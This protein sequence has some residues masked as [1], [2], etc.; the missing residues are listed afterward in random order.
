MPLGYWQASVT[1]TPWGSAFSRVKVTATGMFVVRQPS[2]RLLP[3][4]TFSA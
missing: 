1:F 2:R 4:A 3:S